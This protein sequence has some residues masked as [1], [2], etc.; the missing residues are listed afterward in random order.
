MVER[1]VQAVFVGSNGT[2][3]GN[4]ATAKLTKTCPGETVRVSETVA[5]AV[6]FLT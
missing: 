4:K 6:E 5:K 1:E 2:F 3:V